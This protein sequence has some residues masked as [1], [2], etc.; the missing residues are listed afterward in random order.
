MGVRQM[1]GLG[2]PRCVD[3]LDVIE[4]AQADSFTQEW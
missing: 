2:L 1:A 3:A 4:N